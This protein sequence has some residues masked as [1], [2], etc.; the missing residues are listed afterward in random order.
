VKWLVEDFWEGLKC[1]VVV[2]C[3][4]PCGK[5][6]P[7]TALFEV[8]KL[9]AFKRQGMTAFPCNASGCSQLLDM[10]GLLQNAPA[11]RKPAVESLLTEGF[12]EIR[13]RL[14]DLRRQN[15]VLDQNIRGIMSQ[16]EDAFLSLLQV[17]ANDAKDGPR[18]FSL[19]PVERSKFNPN[20]WAKKKFRVTLW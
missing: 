4:D 15:V 14:E 5:Q 20:G 11:V 2:P 10:D 13:S 3:V 18:L 9:I 8:Q 12:D 17:L 16:V 7:G 1:E 6:S 19:E